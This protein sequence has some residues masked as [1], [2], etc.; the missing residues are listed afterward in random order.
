MF[1]WWTVYL[2]EICSTNFKKPNQYRVFT[3]N[4]IELKFAWEKWFMMSSIQILFASLQRRLFKYNISFE[5]CYLSISK[6]WWNK[7]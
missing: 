1:L 2:N 5:M 3:C 7:P 4:S 6:D